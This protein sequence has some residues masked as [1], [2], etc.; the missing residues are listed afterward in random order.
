MK[1]LLKILIILIGNLMKFLD[2]LPKLNL[3]HLFLPEPETLEYLLTFLS[4]M[5]IQDAEAGKTISVQLLL[6]CS[7]ISEFLYRSIIIF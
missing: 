6:M 7:I 4:L 1:K 3:Q 2:F 5:Q